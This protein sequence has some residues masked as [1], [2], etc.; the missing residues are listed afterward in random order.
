MKKAAADAE[1]KAQQDLAAAEA[2]KAAQAAKVAAA[3]EAKKA[4]AQEGGILVGTG[5]G[6]VRPMGAAQLES[7]NWSKKKTPPAAETE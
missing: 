2:K 1:A 5:D 4:A 7:L 3:A 6:N